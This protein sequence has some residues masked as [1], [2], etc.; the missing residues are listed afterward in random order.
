VLTYDQRSVDLVTAL[1]S[2]AAVAV[3]NARLYEDIERLFEGFVTAAVTAIEQ[4]DPTTSGHSGRVATLTTG[5]ADAITRG[6]APAP[7]GQLVFSREEMKE[8]RYAALLHDFGKVGVREL[9]LVKQKK[10]YPWD[11]HLIRHRFA[12]LNAVTDVEFERERA[13]FLLEHGSEAYP[14]VVGRL[15][16]RRQERQRELRDYLDAI[17]RANEPT[18][19]AE[20]SFE[21]LQAINKRS[22]VDF[23]GVERPLLSPDELRFLMIRRGNLDEAERQEIESHVTHSYRFLD[24][25]PW[26]RDLRSIPDIAFAHHEKLNGTGYPRQLKAEYIPVQ[27]RI[28]TIADIFDALTATDRP[29]K[30]A[31]PT[32]RALDILHD[33]AKGGMIDPHLLQVFTEARVYESVLGI[34]GT[35]AEMAIPSRNQT[36]PYGASVVMPPK[37]RVG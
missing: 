26:T 25:I 14:D 1:T 17:L 22:Y 4:R 20:G 33:E 13:E 18:V 36:P 7:Y 9:V 3:E 8:L 30:R 15:E 32:R 29:Y 21:A 31:V 34:T 35:T 6:G 10:L 2:Q 12:Y 19:L 27:A 11:L 16:E 5:L 28:M 23:D 24:Q 37:G